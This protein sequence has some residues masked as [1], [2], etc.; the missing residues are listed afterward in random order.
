MLSVTLQWKKIHKITQKIGIGAQ[1]G[2]KYFCHDV[3]LFVFRA[4]V[5]L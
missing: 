2:R 4:I 5:L 3:R 1:F